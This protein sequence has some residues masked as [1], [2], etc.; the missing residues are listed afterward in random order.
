[1][2][3]K[4]CTVEIS[5][6]E[7]AAKMWGADDAPQ[8]VIALHG[9]LDNA[10]GFDGLISRFDA[11][12]QIAAVDLPGHGRSQWRDRAD[13]Y[14]F[15]DWV[16]VVVEI[17]DAL[18]WEQFGLLG[19]SMG[20][21]IASLTA[22]VAPDRVKNMVFLDALGPLVTPAGESVKQLRRALRQEKVLW[23]R[24]PPRY[25]SK[26]RMV[27][28]LAMVRDSADE[29]SLRRLVDR[30]CEQDDD[31]RWFFA[32][33]P[34]LKAPSRLRLTEQQVLAFLAGIDCPVLLVRPADGL[35]A[36]SDIEERRIGVIDDIRVVDVQGGHDVHMGAPGRVADSIERFLEQ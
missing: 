4:E 18:E 31:G 9:W 34:R 7:L 17:A 36:A 23:N 25:D 19:H 10:A 30:S 28:T 6:L 27:Q 24:T 5:G 2:K 8:K 13:A 35:V 14:Y 1:M 16:E 22:P 33:D 29:Q 21:S 26:Q 12:L 11:D 20:G 15:T 32:Y 3:C